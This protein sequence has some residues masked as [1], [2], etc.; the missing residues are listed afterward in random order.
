MRESESISWLVGRKTTF[1]SLLYSFGDAILRTAIL[2]AALV[3]FLPACRS[4]GSAENSDSSEVKKALGETEIGRETGAAEESDGSKWINYIRSYPLKDVPRMAMREAYEEKKGIKIER[5][6]GSQTV[7]GNAWRPIGPASTD[8]HYSPVSGRIRALAIDPSDAVIGT[9]YAGAASGGVWK[10]VNGGNSWEPLTD[11]EQSLATGSIAIDPDNPS[12]IYVGTG[13]LGGTYAGAGVLRS[14]DGGANWDLLGNS[15]FQGY[16]I[17]K[18]LL[19]P[20]QISDPQLS[21]IVY[22]ASNA[23]LFRSTDSGLNWEEVWTDSPD[24][25]FTDLAVDPDDPSIVYAGARGL[26]SAQPPVFRSDNYGENGSWA[27][28]AGS[29]L[30]LPQVGYGRVN[31]AASDGIVMVSMEDIRNH[32]DLK[33]VWV[34]H[35]SGETWNR[36]N[37]HPPEFAENSLAP[38]P[39]VLESEPNDTL[40]QAELLMSGQ[41][42][43]GTLSSGSD[44]DYY[45]V[46]IGGNEMSFEICADR[47]GSGFDPRI[48][49]YDSAGVELSYSPISSLPAKGVQNSND[50]R[51]FPSWSLVDP[52]DYYLKVE[53]TDGILSGNGKYQFSVLAAALGCQCGYDQVVAIHPEDPDIMYFGGVRLFRTVDG[54]HTWSQIQDHG[55]PNPSSNWIHPDIHAVAIST[56][57]PNFMLWGTDG[58]VFATQDAGDLWVSLNTNLAITQF[59]QGISQ[60]P[61]DPDFILGGTQDNSV[62]RYRGNAW[63]E[64]RGF[65]GDAGY[66]AIDPTDTT[67]KIWYGSAQKMHLKKTVDDGL[68]AFSIITG[69]DIEDVAFVSP[70]VMDPNDSGTLLAAGGRQIGED[71]NNFEHYVYRYSSSSGSWSVNSQDLG[72]II[73][74]IAFDPGNSETYYAGTYQSKVWVTK[75]TGSTWTDISSTDFRNIVTSLKADPDDSAKLYAT[76]G[77]FN[78]TQVFRTTDGGATWTNIGAAPFSSTPLPNAPIWDL[79]IDP[80]YP[81]TLFASG[82]VGIFKTIDGGINWASFNEDLPNVPVYDI[83]INSNTMK[84]RAATYGRSMWELTQ[85][86]DT[87]I[88]ASSISDGELDASTVNAGND[89]SSSC[90]TSAESP[91]VWYY[92]TAPFAGELAI[93]T[94][95]SVLDTVLSVH[96]AGCPADAT[97]EIP[98]IGCN[99]DCGSALPGCD[100]LDSCLNVPMWAGQ[101]LLIRV[102]GY[103]GAAGDFSLHTEFKRP[104]PTNNVCGSVYL[105]EPGF[106]EGW[107]EEADNDGSS[108]C[109]QS[110]SSPDVWYQYTA[111][112]DGT[113]SAD[114][115]GSDFDTVLSVHTGCPGTVGNE[116]E[117]GCNDECGGSPCAGPASCLSIP[118]DSGD[119]YQFRVAGYLGATGDFDFTVWCTSR[120]DECIDAVRIGDGNRLFSTLDM[121]STAPGS[122]PACSF[123]EIGADIW[124][125]Y[126]VPVNSRVEVDTCDSEFDTRIAVYDSSSCLPTTVPIAC[127][128]N[129]CG[130]PNGEQSRMSFNALGGRDYLIRV[131]GKPLTPSLSVAGNGNLHISS[132]P[133]D[134]LVFADGFESGTTNTWSAAVP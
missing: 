24:R 47:I 89:G 82:D 52:G 19:D 105:P 88:K 23:G 121:V 61:S 30:P 128:D 79:A 28:I 74:A 3:V 27:P 93:D 2:V 16:K 113:L 106:Y 118:V 92:Y 117:N 66:T 46:H 9:F 83:D 49:I 129:D 56:R 86:N 120:N 69:L 7:P 15:I 125:L 131:G 25:C 133:L 54:G 41:V 29:E 67:Q 132:I 124:Y 21:R 33:G 134:G 78:H 95:G 130:S 55:D 39:D 58:G 126:S 48:R 81:D 12:I 59:Y 76:F 123:G 98:D 31:L 110:E 18:I 17:G 65:T 116:V 96:D 32:S 109:G 111:S 94:C 20:T 87:C 99:D 102:S 80:D 72:S 85:R 26:G 75:D 4:T 5:S 70:F 6:A 127:G 77:G 108:S 8:F 40:G 107:T 44:G 84:M 10:T 62:Q 45:R 35:N 119:V 68:H 13:E 101:T 71:P 60:H 11:T 38:H 97:T 53:S 36:I 114:L 112:C 64:P 43:E 104:V 42:V 115:C 50:E 34:S 100:N 90:G 1:S 22:L 37:G 122:I 103:D 91:D 73:S 57:D 51:W 14:F 63:E